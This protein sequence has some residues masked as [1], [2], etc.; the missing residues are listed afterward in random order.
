[1]MK[2]FNE[3]KQEHDRMREVIE[4]L[5]DAGEDITEARVQDMMTE[6]IKGY[7]SEDIQSLLP[8]G[9]LRV[10]HYLSNGKEGWW[11]I[12]GIDKVKSTGD[13]QF[14]QLEP[15]RKRYVTPNALSPRI[16]HPDI[17]TGKRIRPE[18]IASGEWFWVA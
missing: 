2:K 18:Q 11:K 15:A 10:G 5:L 6:G 13:I 12:V 8:R 4:H 3:Y 16:R 14:Y 17:T 9:G 1:M 7:D